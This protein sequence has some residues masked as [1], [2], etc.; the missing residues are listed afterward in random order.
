MKRGHLLLALLAIAAAQE[1]YAASIEPGKIEMDFAP[2]LK[3]AIPFT[4]TG[5][6]QPHI[7]TDCPEYLVYNNDA[8]KQDGKVTFTITISLP[9]KKL[10]Q[11]PTNC[12][13]KASETVPK[14]QGLIQTKI[15][16]IAAVIINSPYKG[17]YATIGLTASNANKGDPIF[18]TITAEN[19]GDQPVKDAQAVIEIKSQNGQTAAT[20]ST[21]KKD[22]MPGSTV[23]LN[24]KL[25]TKMYAPGKYRAIAKMG[26]G[27]GIATDETD[28]IIGEYAV[29][30]VSHPK[31]LEI[32]SVTPFNIEIESMWGKPIDNIYSITTITNKSQAKIAE[33]RTA[34]TALTPWERT[35]LSS[36]IDTAN[37][38]K[39]RYSM[40]INLFYGD[41]ITTK[42]ADI[43]FTEPEKQKTGAMQRAKEI[44][45]NQKF[46]TGLIIAIV[47]LDI[48]W[49]ITRKRKRPHHQGNPLKP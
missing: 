4:L 29:G 31:E 38:K 27:K 39:G 17:E 28:F 15:D 42:S 6:E 14:G 37:F 36:E 25:D 18:F 1:A 23:T 40:S 33:I 10:T 8:K 30:I 19:M 20:L 48:L 26:Y 49:L 46:L 11:G 32:S 7:E 16:L 22:L 47:A 24:K 21:D 43:L 44:A 5:Y 13:V 3:M 12:G 34:S 41:K 45:T 9:D 2:N 35:T